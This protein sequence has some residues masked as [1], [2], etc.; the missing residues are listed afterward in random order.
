MK[1]TLTSPR[2][3]IHFFLQVF[4]A[5]FVLVYRSEHQRQNSFQSRKSRRRLSAHFLLHS[6]RGMVR[7]KGINTVYVVPQILLIFSAYQRRS[8]LSLIGAKSL[9]SIVL[10]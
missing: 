10:S 5:N 9:F 6:M 7:T 8:N 3:M 2:I 4:Q 1:K